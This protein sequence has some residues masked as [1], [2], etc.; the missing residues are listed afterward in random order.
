MIIGAS[1]LSKAFLH[2]EFPELQIFDFPG[3][4]I[5]YSRQ[6]ASLPLAILRQY[7]S[8]IRW[9]KK[10]HFMLHQFIDQY[11]IDGVISDNRYGL[12]SDRVPTVFMTHQVFIRINKSIKLL[13]PAVTRTNLKYIKKFRM[14]WIPDLPG[15][16]N[17]SGELSHKKPLPDHCRFIGPLSRFD[18]PSPDKN[19]IQNKEDY[20]DALVILSGP[21]P[22]RS[23]L[24]KTIVEELK[25]SE[26]ALAIVSGQPGFSNEGRKIGKSILYPHKP[27]HELLKLIQNSGIV[28]SRSGY[29]TVMD[30]AV[31]GKNAVFIPTPGQPEQLYLGEYLEGKGWYGCLQQ[32]EFSISK[33]LDK[34][35]NLPG[36]HMPMEQALLEGAISD[37]LQLI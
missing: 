21:E 14:C 36:M 25:S 19:Y 33:A 27:T 12:Y 16:V 5:E 28:I 22:Q 18:N 34:S 6:G 13:E 35:K 8:M 10:E 9:I 31:L 30:L 7:P 1:N 23:M 11:Q 37:F 4:E 29:S 32:N 15:S 3:H 17:L 20:Y 2:T 26:I 24:E